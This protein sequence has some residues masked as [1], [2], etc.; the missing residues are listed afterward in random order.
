MLN[1]KGILLKDFLYK[2]GESLNRNTER[3]LVT[4]SAKELCWYHDEREY[5]E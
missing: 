1:S 3:R 4:L 2:Q 5:E